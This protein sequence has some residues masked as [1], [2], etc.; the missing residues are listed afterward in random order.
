MI[1]Q[2]V[3]GIFIII[4]FSCPYLSQGSLLYFVMDFR[5][6]G[7]VAFLLSFQSFLKTISRENTGRPELENFA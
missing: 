3:S 1:L 5:F 4:N 7:I 6:K 2:S